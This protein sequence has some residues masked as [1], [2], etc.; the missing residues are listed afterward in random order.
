MPEDSRRVQGETGAEMCQGAAW[1]AAG[2]EEVV[3]ARRITAVRLAGLPDAYADQ[4]QATDPDAITLEVQ[5]IL[6]QLRERDERIRRALTFGRA[7]P[8]PQPLVA[9]AS[10]YYRRAE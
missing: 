1:L 5:D 2:Y 7:N 6:T 4:V 8:D 9:E 10:V 3:Q